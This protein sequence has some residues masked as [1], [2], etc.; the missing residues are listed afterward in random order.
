VSTLKSTVPDISA[1]K[2]FLAVSATGNMTSAAKDL[3]L[4]QSAV[5]QAIRQLEEIL[6]TVLIDRSQR[7]LTPTAAGMVLQRRA[8]SLVDDAESL[9]TMVRQAGASKL[10]E[11]RI[12]IIDSFASTV[13]PSLIR[14]LL[15][16]VA[17]VSLRSGLA[18]DQAEGLLTRNL[19]VIVNSDALEDVDGLDRYQIL[20]ESFVLVLPEKLAA[21][22]P[23]PDLRS[24]AASYS[25]V[26]FS[27]RSQTGA[28]IERH[29]RRLGI[30][31][32]RLVEV[33]AT[34]A[35]VRMVVADVGWSIAT[36]LCLLQVRSQ[37]SGVRVLPLPG[38][39]FERQLHLIA[40]SGEYGQL[41][42]RI[43]RICCDILKRECLPEVHKL[44]PWG[45]NLMVIG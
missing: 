27:A 7:P 31:A 1:L 42:E 6:G 13:G 24:L 21:A 5:S 38:P 22:T 23:K 10:P 43:A 12:G 39:S 40:R 35:L 15:K 16:E 41:P 45:R 34:D 20:S 37:M 30:K 25:L 44:L 28:Q 2:V 18:H 8:A 19:D 14:S 11:L 9:V 26:R 36:P 4:T 33:D 29:L 32:P 17:R 3:G